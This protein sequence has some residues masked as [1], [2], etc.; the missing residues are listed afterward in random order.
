VTARSQRSRSHP[1]PAPASPPQSADHACNSLNVAYS[2]HFR[3]R[4]SQHRLAIKKG[5]N[6]R[7][8]SLV[9]SYPG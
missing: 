4:L 1:Q 2:T 8:V 3:K 7:R 5:D 9:L 6:G